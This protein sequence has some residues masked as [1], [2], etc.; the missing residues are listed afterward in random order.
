ML[1][2]IVL[3][4]TENCVLMWFLEKRLDASHE[5]CAEADSLLTT[6]ASVF[7]CPII[8]PD[9]MKINDI[10]TA[11]DGMSL[12]SLSPAQSEFYKPGL[13]ERYNKFLIYFE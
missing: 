6:D 7:Y 5:G 2:F 1:L 12:S 8:D 10:F 4:T 13:T 11:V 9:M 3:A